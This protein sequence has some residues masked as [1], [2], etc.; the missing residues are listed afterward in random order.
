[1]KET[2]EH[3]SFSSFSSQFIPRIR[4]SNRNKSVFHLAVWTAKLQLLDNASSM[5]SSGQKW[6]TATKLHGEEKTACRHHH[7]PYFA[8][9]S[10]SGSVIV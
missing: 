6:H 1:L 5:R 7:C 2:V 3:Y 4:C 10:W 9:A 8:V